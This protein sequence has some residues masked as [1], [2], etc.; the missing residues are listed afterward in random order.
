VVRNPDSVL[1]RETPLL[2][3][4]D[5]VTVDCADPMTPDQI[6]AAFREDPFLWSDKEM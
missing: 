5:P 1:L 2:K 4:V 3:L 6:R